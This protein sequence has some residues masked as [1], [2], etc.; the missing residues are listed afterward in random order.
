MMRFLIVMALLLAGPFQEAADGQQSG[1]TVYVN[2]SDKLIADWV[3]VKVNGGS[4]RWF[5]IESDGSIRLDRAPDDTARIEF[6]FM[7]R[8]PGGQRRIE[9]L[10]SSSQTVAL[11]GSG[12]V[13][14]YVEGDLV[15]SI[16]QYAAVAWAA[17]SPPLIVRLNGRVMGNTP[18]L[19][20]GVQP[21]VRQRFEWRNLSNALVCRQ[22]N[23]VLQPSVRLKFTCD[24]RSRQ[25]TV[26]AF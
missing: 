26:S 9:S 13:T 22:D 11:N 16:E 3:V 15:K 18:E 4:E 2:T 5:E 17:P 19:I 10:G 7:Y 23:V 1:L 14:V 21:R 12:V 24:P 8:R 6:A 25:V 20:R